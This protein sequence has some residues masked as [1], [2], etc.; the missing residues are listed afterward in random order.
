MKTCVDCG[1]TFERK[2]GRICNTCTSKRYRARH[3]R[4]RSATD[5]TY[6]PKAV[7][8]SCGWC[9]MEY[10]TRERRTTACSAVHGRWLSTHGAPSSNK[11]LVHIPVEP[12]RW[13]S[14]FPTDSSPRPWW[15]L[16]ISGPCA[17][18]G[19]IFTA[20]TTT[21]VARLCSKRCAT[22][23]TRAK[24]GRFVIADTRRRRLHDRDKWTCCI[25]G[26]ATSRSFSSGDPWSPTLDHIEPQA[27][28]LIPDHSD[29]NLRTAHYLCNALR[30]DGVLTDEEVREVLAARLATL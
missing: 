10:E 5:L 1:R 18:C 29:G 4:K 11:A 17:W 23:E 30:R 24:R 22:Q 2:H 25:C 16:F 15:V 12:K 20:A 28:A 9:G 7:V 6:R 27:A 8:K 14:R 21:G 13:T 26:E 19:E 3:G